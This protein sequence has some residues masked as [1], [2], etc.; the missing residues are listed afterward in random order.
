[1]SYTERVK[2]LK[3]QFKMD[4]TGEEEVSGTKVKN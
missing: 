4:W 3:I 2:F 1:M